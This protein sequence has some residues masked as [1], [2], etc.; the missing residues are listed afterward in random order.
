MTGPSP[1]APV[2]QGRAG[3]ALWD[4]WLAT[5]LVAVIGYGAV[6]VGCSGVAAA[7]FDR[8]GFGPGAAGITTVAATAHLRLVYGV[9]GAVL[10][11]WMLLLWAVAGGPL[12]RRERWAWTAMTT[13]V[14]A[15]FVIDT[16]FSLA[17]G[18][19][20]HAV[21]NLGFAAALGIPLTG[22]HRHLDP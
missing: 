2:A 20:A 9:L 22:L 7:L 21:F 3:S 13:S 10:I 6:L 5:A 8:L 16:T 12:R 18:A 1:H 17:I 15:W 19:T 4:R 14:T 11:G